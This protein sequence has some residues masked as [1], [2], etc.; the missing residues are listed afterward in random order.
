MDKIAYKPDGTI[1]TDPADTDME[2]DINETLLL[3]GIKK[4]DGTVRDLSLIHI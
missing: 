1:Y 3:N 4:A 2:K